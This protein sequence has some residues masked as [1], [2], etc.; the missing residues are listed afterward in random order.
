MEDVIVVVINYRLHA[1]GFLSL[2]S[3][4]ISGNAG[5][6]DQQLALQ[7]VHEN[8]SSFN[9]DPDSICLFGESAGAACVHLHVLNEKSNKFIKSAIMQSSYATCDWLFQRDGEGK[10]RKL[11]NIL[12]AQST[13]DE[14]VYNVLMKASSQELYDKN[15]KTSSLSD[16]DFRR[17]LPFTFKPVLEKESDEAFITMCPGELL[18]RQKINI[19][20]IFGLNNGDG[21]TMGSY[22][23]NNR[24][25]SFDKDYMRMVP[26]SLNV[27]PSTDEATKVAKEIKEFYFGDKPIDKQTILQFVQFMTD[28]NFAVPMLMSNELHARYYQ[29]GF[30]Q[31][32][33][34]FCYVG[35]LNAFK[36]MLNMTELPGACHFDELFYLF[37]AKMLVMKVAENSSAGQMRKTM[38]KMWTNFAKYHD[39]T[40]GHHNPLPFKWNQVG[41]ADAKSKNF[42]I[43]YLAIDEESKMKKNLYKDR[44]DFWRALYEK[45][46]SGLTNPKY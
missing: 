14:E 12:G 25:P 31:Y 5:L 36:R 45:Y 41:S 16:D 32:V 11:A 20:V 40:P 1:L 3:K 35:E 46:N 15:P 28:S 43:D 29:P 19:P 13:D 10:T 27:D 38:C 9:G 33:Y 30:K 37:D 7:W 34:E 22:Y 6:K 26:L 2:P 8:I 21:M 24:F 17:S 18:K 44:M 4:G 39:P 42:E 23:S